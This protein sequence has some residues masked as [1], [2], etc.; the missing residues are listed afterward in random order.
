M[1]NPLIS[2]LTVLTQIENQIRN[3]EIETLTIIKDHINRIHYRF[4]KLEARVIPK[5]RKIYQGDN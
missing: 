1:N 3:A 2:T 4:D 5:S